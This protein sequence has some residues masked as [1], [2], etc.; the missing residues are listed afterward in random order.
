MNP[1]I[2]IYK[3]RNRIKTLISGF[4]YE[5]N[6]RIEDHDKSSFETQERSLLDDIVA[7]GELQCGSEEYNKLKES[8]DNKHHH[9]SNSHHPEYFKFGIDGMSLLDLI[10]MLCDWKAIA[11]EHRCDFD[12]VLS[13]NIKRFNISPQLESVIRNTIKEL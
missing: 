10:E 12:Q 8:I 4:I 11:A 1:E 3:H 6:R 9:A 13:E 2:E 5:L 7:L